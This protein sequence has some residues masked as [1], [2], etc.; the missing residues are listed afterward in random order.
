MWILRQEITE[1]RILQLMYG[2]K[3]VEREMNPY[4]CLVP[5]AADVLKFEEITYESI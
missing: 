5:A 2:V 4:P 1:L 3:V